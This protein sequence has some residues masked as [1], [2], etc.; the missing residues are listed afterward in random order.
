MIYIVGHAIRWRID[1][2]ADAM[3]MTFI[4]QSGTV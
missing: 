1:R 2:R 3:R 4:R